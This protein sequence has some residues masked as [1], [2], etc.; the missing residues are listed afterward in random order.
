MEEDTSVGFREGR[1]IGGSSAGDAIEEHS[2]SVAA[3]AEKTADM[4]TGIFF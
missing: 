4:D 1:Q 2:K 3:L